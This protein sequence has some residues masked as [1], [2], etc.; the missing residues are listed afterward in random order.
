MNY[1]EAKEIGTMERACNH[2]E[3]VLKKIATKGETTIKINCTG[4]EFT[5]HRGDSLHLK[6]QTIY[7]QLREKLAEYQIVARPK[8][9][10][11]TAPFGAVN[12]DG[13]QQSE[14]DRRL[15]EKRA[16]N[17]EYQRRYYARRKQQ[18]LAAKALEEALQ[19]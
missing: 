17:R 5:V 6:L 7:A 18:R 9:K 3:K 4:L 11:T 8:R 12:T 19:S 15:E 13:G 1:K 2:C 16:R 14:E 10:I